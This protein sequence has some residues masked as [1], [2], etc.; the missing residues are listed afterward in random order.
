M[1]VANRYARALADVVGERGDYRKIKQ[2]VEDFAA[3]Y[4]ASPELREVFD[5]PALPLTEKAKVLEAVTRRLGTTSITANFLRV[6]VVNYRMEALGEIGRAFHKLANARLGVVEV[7]VVSAAGLSEAERQA[8]RAR[9]IEL[10]GKQVEFDFH[11]D[12]ELLGG[13]LAQVGS[14]VYDGSVRGQ[15][16]RIRQRLTEQ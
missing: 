16:Q 6:L 9:F 3:V 15:L 1:A 12:P 7:K 14:T 4:R 5:T 2:E 10:T 11:L 8:L 13:I